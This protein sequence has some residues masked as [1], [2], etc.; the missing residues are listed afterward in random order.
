[1]TSTE[2][3]RSFVDAINSGNPD[4]LAELMTEGHVFVDSDGSEHCGRE[5]MRDGWRSYFSMVPDFRIQVK[6]TFARGNVVVLLGV[7][8][9]TF[10]QAGALKP[11]NHW[12]VPAAWRVVVEDELV[13]VWQL[14]VNPE[15]MVKISERIADA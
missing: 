7:A 4:R 6:D 12:V 2:T 3:A 8:E 1:M 13:A 5:Q 15:P 11:E 9:G 10:D 14:Y